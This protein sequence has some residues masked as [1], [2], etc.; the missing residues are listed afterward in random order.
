M[1]AQWISRQLQP[2]YY[3]PNNSVSFNDFVKLQLHSALRKLTSNDQTKFITAAIR[4]D[5]DEDGTWV[6]IPSISEANL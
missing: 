4:R 5:Q 1:N 6:T 2:K 3:H